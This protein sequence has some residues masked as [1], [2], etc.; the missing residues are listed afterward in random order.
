ML[1]YCVEALYWNAVVFSAWSSFSMVGVVPVNGG[2]SQMTS[3]ARPPEDAGED[4][5][6][7]KEKLLDALVEAYK[8]EPAN[9][10][11]AA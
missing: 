1:D 6:T 5:R 2:R 10:G 8:M 4:D 3:L 9:P 11:V 7:R